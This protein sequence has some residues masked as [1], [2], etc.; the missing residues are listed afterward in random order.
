MKLDFSAF[1]CHSSLTLVSACANVQ[2][3]PS[4]QIWTAD[5]VRKES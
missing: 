1:V 4:Q 5:R 3:F 2:P